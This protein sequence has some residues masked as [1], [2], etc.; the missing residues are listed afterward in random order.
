V[1]SVSNTTPATDVQG[2][3]DAAIAWASNHD[4]SIARSIDLPQ[5][6]CGMRSI[7]LVFHLIKIRTHY[8]RHSLHV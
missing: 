6:F 5:H 3:I 7:S 1:D 8:C 4:R 2:D